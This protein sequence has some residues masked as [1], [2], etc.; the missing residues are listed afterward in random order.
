MLS[1][2]LEVTHEHNI[3]NNENRPPFAGKSRMHELRAKLA[4]LNKIL[5]ACPPITL[6]NYKAADIRLPFVWP[7]SYLFRRF[8]QVMPKLWHHSKKKLCLYID[9]YKQKMTVYN[10]S[11]SRSPVKSLIKRAVVKSDRLSFLERNVHLSFCQYV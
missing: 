7:I 9:L 1:T 5:P 4:E 2:V 10:Y 11:A 3:S 8:Q 6:N